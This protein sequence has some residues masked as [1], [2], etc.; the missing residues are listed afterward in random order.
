M[1]P[2]G[3][4]PDDVIQCPVCGANADTAWL[5]VTS[6]SDPPGKRRYIPGHSECPTSPFH[7]VT[8]AYDGLRLVT[9]AHPDRDEPGSCTLLRLD[10]WRER[11]WYPTDPEHQ[12]P[13][14]VVHE[15]VR[16]IQAG[17]WAEALT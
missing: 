14:E 13:T 6:L 8:P 7:D 10:Y 17:A 5:D 11:G 4:S 1:I 16:Q 9:V 12:T 15:R 2:N 3:Y